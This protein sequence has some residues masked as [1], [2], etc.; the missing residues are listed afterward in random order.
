[1][2]A[3]GKGAFVHEARLWSS[4]GSAMPQREQPT[5]A[6]LKAHVLTDS[7]NIKFACIS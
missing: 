1:M 7:C 2:Q 5:P 3:L 4:A 6:T